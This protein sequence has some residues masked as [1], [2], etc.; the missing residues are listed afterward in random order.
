MRLCRL[1]SRS[2][3]NSS[4]LPKWK[5]IFGQHRTCQLQKQSVISDS[6][7]YTVHSLLDCG[8]K[9]KTNYTN[10]KCTVHVEIN[11]RKILK[12]KRKAKVK[13]LSSRHDI[14]EWKLN[15][16]LPHGLGGEVS[17]SMTVNFLTFGLNISH[18]ATQLLVSPV[19][20]W[21]LT[22]RG[23]TALCLRRNFFPVVQ[24]R[25]Q[26]CIL[27]D[28]TKGGMSLNNFE[29]VLSNCERDKY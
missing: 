21:G 27:S 19:I 14:W 22:T 18:W 9:I 16:Y 25:T 5:R 7:I 28:S 20:K 26:N 3:V 12:W 8:D 24:S 13:V 10:Q 23:F 17:G 4:G 15:N 6:T 1:D 29:P 2:T 11:V